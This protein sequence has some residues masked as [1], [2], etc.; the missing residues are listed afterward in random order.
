MSTDLVNKYGTFHNPAQHLFA[1]GVPVAGP[2]ERNID[3]M[4]ER[5]TRNKASLIIID[6]GL[7]EGKTTLGIHLADLYQGSE[8]NLAVQ[9]AM[10]G[11][12]FRKKIE[13][14]ASMGY[15]VIV[16]DESGDFGKRGA[17]SKFNATLVRLFDT[18]RVYR[19]LVILILPLFNYLDNT[20]FDKQ[21]PRLLLHC[22]SRDNSKGYYKAYS[23]RR[24]F[25]LKDKMSK[26]LL[27]PTA[28]TKV[29][30]NFYG[31]F[32]G[33]YPERAK[34]VDELGSKYKRKINNPLNRPDPMATGMK[35]FT[36]NQ[37][38]EIFKVSPDWVKWQVKKGALVS[39]GKKGKANIYSA[40]NVKEVLETRVHD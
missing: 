17:L 13:L 15:G 32:Y 38:A 28:Y 29:Y 37:V 6:G 27:K 3:C 2:M 23:L 34:I 35:H 25:Y 21:I 10:G 8:I 33:L 40:S 12:D 24:M 14:C 22:H 1:P 18:F 20:L 5:I 7:G 11:D 9:Y 31:S 36:R 30:P 4:R 19:V 16:Y 39:V 26:L